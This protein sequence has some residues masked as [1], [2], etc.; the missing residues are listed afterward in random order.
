[1]S[2]TESGAGG[3]Y[4][5][6][7]TGPV[8]FLDEVETG[9]YR[10]AQAFALDPSAGDD[11]LERYTPDELGVSAETIERVGHFL[12]AASEL[13]NRAHWLLIG[14]PAAEAHA[15]YVVNGGGVIE[16]DTGNLASIDFSEME[17]RLADREPSAEDFQYVL[18]QQKVIDANP[19]IFPDE[20]A[21]DVAELI[22]RA[23]R[24]PAFPS[25]GLES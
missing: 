7:E 15:A 5:S 11:E 19:G 9:L 24:H 6:D 12:Y 23:K 13:A 18:D 14:K 4:V 22:D 25:T 20:T 10:M 3:G 8:K 2:A 17:A 16:W 1:M 21:Q